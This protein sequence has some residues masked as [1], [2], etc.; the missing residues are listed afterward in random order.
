MKQVY[1]H[2]EATAAELAPLVQ[3]VA[4]Q[5]FTLPEVPMLGRDA[6]RAQQE[7]AINAEIAR[8]V[9]EANQRLEKAGNV[10]VAHAGSTERAD[11]LARQLGIAQGLKQGQ[12][13]QL[14]AQTTRVEQMVTRSE[15]LAVQLAEGGGPLV[16]QLTGYGQREREK[17]RQELVEV[18]EGLLAGPVRSGADF[19]AQ[20]AEVDYS[21]G[22]EADKGLIIDGG[23]GSRF[24]LDE[25]KPHGQDLA[26]QFNAAIQRTQQAEFLQSEA[27][28]LATEQAERAAR[29]QQ[30][31]QGR[32][33]RKCRLRT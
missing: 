8:Q 14:E 9:G 7:A 13:A 29:G 31:H 33:V 21:M 22:K 3:P 27:G 4:A 20:L 23:T 15:H 5:A 1:G 30:A 28:K 10:A 17:A 24:R 16:T 25:L 11:V 26:P 12:Y 2:Q 18:M 6:W 32:A 19:F